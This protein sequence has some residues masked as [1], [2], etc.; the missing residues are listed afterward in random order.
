MRNIHYSTEG[1]AARKGLLE[2]TYFHEE[3]LKQQR[4]RVDAQ[5]CA[6]SL[7]VF[8][9]N[10]CNQLAINNKVDQ[11]WVTRYIHTHTKHTHTHLHTHTHTKHTHT[12][13][14]THMHTYVYTYIHVYIHT[15]M[16]A[17]M[18]TYTHT[19]I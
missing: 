8:G 18:H 13:T 19:N 17:C 15:C 10:M 1:K 9:G 16:H 4:R 14:H 12:H 7:Y 6:N 2:S 5:A 3:D 11:P